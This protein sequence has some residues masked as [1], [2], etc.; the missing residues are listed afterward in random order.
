MVVLFK[1]TF[2]YFVTALFEPAYYVLGK[3]HWFTKKSRNKKI[4]K[5]LTV[6][7]ENPHETV[8]LIMKLGYMKQTRNIPIQIIKF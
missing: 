6:G 1:R 7:I 5:L 8:N 3:K 2:L 4:K